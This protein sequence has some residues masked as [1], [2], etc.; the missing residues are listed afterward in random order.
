MSHNSAC[1]GNGFNVV[2]L[3]LLL[4]LFRFWFRFFVSVLGLSRLF[5][6]KTHLLLL[7]PNFQLQALIAAIEF[8]VV[9]FESCRLLLL[10]L[11]LLLVYYLMLLSSSESVNRLKDFRF[12]SLCFNRR[13]FIDFL[14]FCESVRIQLIRSII[15]RCDSR[16]E[17]I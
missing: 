11:L 17:W 1:H 4:L 9:G 7:F 15:F 8:E 6:F 10:P 5:C 12:A 2:P 13:A 3:L 14:V 16:C